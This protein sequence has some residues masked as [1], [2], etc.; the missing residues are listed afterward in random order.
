MVWNNQVIPV[1]CKEYLMLLCTWLHECWGWAKKAR[2]LE[3]L[4]LL[5]KITPENMPDPTD[6]DFGPDVGLEV[7]GDENRIDLSEKDWDLFQK[8]L[9]RPPKPLNKKLEKLIKGYEKSGEGISETVVARAIEVFE[10]RENAL[11]WLNSPI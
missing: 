10:T 7:I 6:T 11:K 9:E 8:I 4:E 1:G 5:T 2:G 3:L